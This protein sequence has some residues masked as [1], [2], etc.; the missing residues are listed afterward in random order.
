METSD[1]YSAIKLISNNDT[2]KN[3]IY[4]LKR[5]DLLDTN[6]YKIG[7][8]ERSLYKRHNEYKIKN[9]TVLYYLPVDNIVNAIKQL[10]IYKLKKNSNLKFRSD[11]GNEYFEGEYN[12]ILNTIND[13][14]NDYR[15]DHNVDIE[16]YIK[17]SNENHKPT[18]KSKNN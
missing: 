8:T 2:I 14:C 6:I 11:I 1:N 13:I 9:T 4:I 7:K 17:L 15:V 10:I 18:L 3:G 12:I 5:G 16:N